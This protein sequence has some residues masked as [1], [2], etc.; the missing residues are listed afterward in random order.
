VGGV[1][2]ISKCIKEHHAETSKRPKDRDAKSGCSPRARREVVPGKFF[3]RSATS[4]ARCTGERV[5]ARASE[6]ERETHTYT[7]KKKGSKQE[8]PEGR[9]ERT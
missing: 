1:A 8:K 7:E 2:E 4:F 6:R 5:R 3:A 9:E